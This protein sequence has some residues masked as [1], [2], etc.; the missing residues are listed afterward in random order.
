MLVP[1]GTAKTAPL[2]VLTSWN[3]GE[4]AGCEVFI[5]DGHNGLTG[6]RIA[7]AHQAVIPRTQDAWIIGN[8]EKIEWP[9][10]GYGNSGAWSCFVYNTDIFDHTFHVRYLVADFASLG[11]AGAAGPALL[12]P[13][14]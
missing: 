7:F 8:D 4:L 11:N 10:S 6:L 13:L 1:A 5:P 14:S 3:Q 2:E 12:P 9:L